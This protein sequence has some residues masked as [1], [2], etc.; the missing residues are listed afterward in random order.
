MHKYTSVSIDSADGYSLHCRYWA[1]S[2][3]KALAILQHGV[4]SHSG[5]LDKV[6]AGLQNSGISCVAM[7]RRGAGENHEAK[8]DVPSSGALFDDLDAVLEWCSSKRLPIHACG[9]CWGANYWVNYLAT[10]DNHVLSLA[11][12]APS[13]FPSALI[14]EQTLTLGDSPN[15]DQRPLIPIE[16]FTDGP[17]F[18]DLIEPDPLRLRLV[19]TRFNQTMAEFSQAVWM[20]VLRLKTPLLVA[21]ASNDTVVDNDATRKVVERFTGAPKMLIELPGMHGIQFDACDD[22]VDHLSDWILKHANKKT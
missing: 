15:A 20:K 1:A 2:T 4:V 16:C 7:D 17:Y 6:C 11:L 22:L 13:L 9:F 18:R 19:S 8:G 3:P 12:I 10:K 14:K 21:L 5:W